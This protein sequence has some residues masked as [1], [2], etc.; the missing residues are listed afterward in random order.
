MY[1]LAH[2]PVIVKQGMPD[3]NSIPIL[4]LNNIFMAIFLHR[5]RQPM[6]TRLLKNT[7]NMK[8]KSKINGKV[9]SDTPRNRK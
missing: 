8:K 3:S 2:C 9:N 1:S 7:N 6:T 4:V 5:R